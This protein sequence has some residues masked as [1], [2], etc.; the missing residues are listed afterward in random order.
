M[1]KS[2]K[3]MGVKFKTRRSEISLSLKEVENVTSIRMS[4]LQAI[5]EDRVHTMIS[6]VYARGFIKQYASFLGIDEDEIIQ[7]NLLNLD[8]SNESFKKDDT[9]YNMASLE[10]RGNQGKNVK[11]LPNAMWVGISI[12]VVLAAWYMAKYLEVI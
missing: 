7:E 6:H 5:E 10:V 12:V 2:L 8:D 1:V 3:P 4:Y 11:W 9:S